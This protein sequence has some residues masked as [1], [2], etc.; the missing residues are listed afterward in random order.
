MEDQTLKVCGV[1]S[2]RTC[3]RDPGQLLWSK[4]GAWLTTSEGALELTRL[5]RAGK[6]V[7]PALQ[8][9]QPWGASGSRQ[10]G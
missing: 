2:L 7:Q 10:L 9:L 8:A 5:Q 3:Y 4:E 6:P 1:G